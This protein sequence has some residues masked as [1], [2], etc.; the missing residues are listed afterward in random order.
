[1]PDQIIF[2]NS[3]GSAFPPQGRYWTTPEMLD[4]KRFVPT[5]TQSEVARCFFAHT[6][7]WLRRQYAAGHH[8]LI[9]EDEP[10]E[11][12]ANPSS[13]RPAYRLYDIERLAHAL[14]QHQ[15][16]TGRELELVV[17]LVK[18]SARLYQYL[19]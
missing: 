11:P 12:L 9:D 1:M 16:I 2:D 5:Y 18:T 13:G 7:S 14:A 17:L 3:P 10:V 8:H 6:A 15:V 19:S 4:T